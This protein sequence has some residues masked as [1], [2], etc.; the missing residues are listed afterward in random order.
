M[1]IRND[2]FGLDLGYSC[3]DTHQQ[4][5]NQG[6]QLAKSEFQPYF[7]WLLVRAESHNQALQVS[8]VVIHQIS[9]ILFSLEED[10]Y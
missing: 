6:P 5:T 3:V 8:E 1:D 10:L 2:A 9:S 4:T 7:Q